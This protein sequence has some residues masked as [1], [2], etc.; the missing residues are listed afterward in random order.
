MTHG[1]L[2]DNEPHSLKLTMNPVFFKVQK[3]QSVRMSSVHHISVV[4]DV[5]VGNIQAVR[6]FQYEVIS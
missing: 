2:M 5:P 1:T 6:I 3:D 4:K